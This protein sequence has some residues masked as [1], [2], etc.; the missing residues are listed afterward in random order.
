MLDPKIRELIKRKSQ[1]NPLQGAP[2]IHGIYVSQTTVARYLVRTRKPPSQTWR[3]F[4]EN[5]PG[6]SSPLISLQCRPRPFEYY[7]FWSCSVTIAGKSS[8]RM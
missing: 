6:R 1:A 8:T 4:L 3:T 7:F 2:R 5:N